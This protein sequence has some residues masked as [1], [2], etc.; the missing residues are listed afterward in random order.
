[1]DSVSRG[2]AG[3][4]GGRGSEAGSARIAETP[5]WGPNSELVNGKVMV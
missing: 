3:R 5:M 2:G 1:M 4:K